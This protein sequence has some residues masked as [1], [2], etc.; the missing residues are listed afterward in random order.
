MILVSKA[1]KPPPRLDALLRD[2]LAQY[3]DAALKIWPGLDK[4]LRGL[5]NEASMSRMVEAFRTGQ[6][7]LVDGAIDWAS[8]GAALSKELGPGIRS[9]LEEGGRLALRQTPGVVHLDWQ[10]L[11]PFVTN[12]MA[13]HLPTLIREVTDETRAAV[14]LATR[15]AYEQGMGPMAAART[16]RGSIGLTT[17][18]AQAVMSFRAGVIDAAERDLGVDY[19][20]RNWAMSRDVVRSFRQV[21]LANADKLASAYQ[22][23]AVMGR[24]MV[25]AR[26]EGVR[27]VSAGRK[28]FW[29]EAMQVGALDPAH[30][31]MMWLASPSERTCDICM[32][33]HKTTVPV[34]SSFPDGDPPLHP[35]CRCDVRIVDARKGRTSAA[36]ARTDERIRQIEQERAAAEDR[37]RE[38]QQAI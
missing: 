8:L 21:T 7:R 15:M 31:E 24:A 19:L 23:R 34:G 18:Q 9:A 16:I 6:L 12:Y 33:L 27:A 11:D 32:R 5:V 14:R 35:S 26:T 3:E 13:T 2:A 29:Q 38:A 30:H 17:K 20:H 10:V 25:I 36:A 28:A 22:R 4:V 37:R 1:R